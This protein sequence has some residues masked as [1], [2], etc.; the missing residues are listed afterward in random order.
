VKRKN[1]PTTTMGAAVMLL[2]ITAGVPYFA[3]CTLGP[4]HTPSQ[5]VQK[6]INVYPADLVQAAMLTTKTMR[7]GLSLEDWVKHGQS[8][9]GDFRYVGGQVI[10]ENV[11]GNKAEVTVDAKISSPL[12]KHIQREQFR[13]ILLDRN[14]V[15]EAQAVVMGFPAPPSFS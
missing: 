8:V 12:G 14:W 6:W 7:K 1:I 4:D 9:L 15:I 11:N 2:A 13:L 5:V 10:S 3:G